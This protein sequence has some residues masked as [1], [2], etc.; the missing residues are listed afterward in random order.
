M[1]FPGSLDLLVVSTGACCAEAGRAA[2][3]MTSDVAMSVLCMERFPWI[4][5]NVN[6]ID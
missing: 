2:I 1:T 6:V 3:N 5:M 4:L